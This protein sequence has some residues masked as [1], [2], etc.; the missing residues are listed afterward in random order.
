MLRTCKHQRSVICITVLFHPLSID[1]AV[2]HRTHWLPDTLQ[3]A[4]RNLIQHL[5]SLEDG[6]IYL[7]ILFLVSQIIEMSEPRIGNAPH[8]REG[9][10]CNTD[11]R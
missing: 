5:E 6:T 1:R 4:I 11:R 8:E 3:N 2:T 9:R 7:Q 10:E